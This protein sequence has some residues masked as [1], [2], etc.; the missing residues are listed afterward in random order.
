MTS[1]RGWRACSAWY[2]GSS[3]A[4]WASEQ[5]SEGSCVASKASKASKQSSRQ[6]GVSR[7]GGANHSM[8]RKKR[9]QSQFWSSSARHRASLFDS[10]FA[11]PYSVASVA[12]ARILSRTLSI[13]CSSVAMAAAQS[14]FFAKQSDLM[15][16]S[17]WRQ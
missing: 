10:C 16:S 8:P 13:P 2:C 17:S 9:T 4:R 15:N 12:C 5:A 6:L 3:S 7:A 14:F 1:E 11:R